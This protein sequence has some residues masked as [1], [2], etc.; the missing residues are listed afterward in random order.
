MALQPIAKTGEVILKQQAHPVTLFDQ[1][2]QR[3]A[4]DMME[5]MLAAN[6]VGIAAPQ[7]H[8]PLAMFIVASRP[9]ARYPDAPVMEPEVM[10]N[11]AIIHASAE[12]EKAEEGCL[13]VP[14]TR[15]EIWRYR[16]IEV[17]YQ[18]LQGNWQQ[19]NL[20]GFVA[21]VFQHELDHLNGMTL[22]ERVKLAEQSQ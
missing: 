16:Q 1:P 4:Q 18:D 2:L 3:L 9:N 6:G 22:L 7:I 8:Y 10:I 13:S 19:R 15:L 17:R 21:R 20:E 14:D 5:T 12:M 11:P